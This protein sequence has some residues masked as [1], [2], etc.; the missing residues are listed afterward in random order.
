M[1]EAAVKVLIVDD[2]PFVALSVVSILEDYDIETEVVGSGE[3][4]LELVEVSSYDI[5]LVDLRLPAMQGDEL[6]PKLHVIQPEMKF[7]VHT[8]STWFE[9][10]E[11]LKKAGVRREHLLY[12]PVV[13]LIEIVR[14]V[15]ELAGRNPEV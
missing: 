6:I 12:K 10:T 8:G 14:V 15:L 11:G 7:V 3:Q 4:A 13:D 9:L 5:A 1:S 2:E